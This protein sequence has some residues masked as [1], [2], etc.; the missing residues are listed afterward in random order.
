MYFEDQEEEAAIF[1]FLRFDHSIL[2][3]HVVRGRQRAA[4]VSRSAVQSSSRHAVL[5]VCVCV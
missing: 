5:C 2:A 4:G 3:V 1:Q